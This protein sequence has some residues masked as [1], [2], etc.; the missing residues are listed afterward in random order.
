MFMA[1]ASLRHVV[2][3][4]AVLGAAALVVSACGDPSNP[5]GSSSTRPST[6]ATR[7]ARPLPGSGIVPRL[8]GLTAS[9]AQ[10]AVAKAKVEGGVKL[11]AEVVTQEVVPGT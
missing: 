1:R 5:T 3:S 7:P 4:I 6:S 9:Q 11:T 10:L 8:V 2:A